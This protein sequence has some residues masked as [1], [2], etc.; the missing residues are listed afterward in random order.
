LRT[1]FGEATREFRH[2]CRIAGRDDEYIHGALHRTI[3][4]QQDARHLRG[5]SGIRRTGC[6][7]KT[8]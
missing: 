7:D 3:T 1:G 4:I 8:E 5:E 2:V 6:N